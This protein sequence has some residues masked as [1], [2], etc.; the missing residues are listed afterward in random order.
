MKKNLFIVITLCVSAHS[1]GQGEIDAYRFSKNDLSGTAR[2]QAMG[3]AFGAL[4]GD[5]TGVTINPA[6]IGI[7][8]SSEIIFNAGLTFNQTEA[9]FNRTE[10][11][12]GNAKLSCDNFAYVGYFPL[13]KDDRYSLNFGFIYN[14]LKSFDRKYKVSGERMGTSLTDYMADITFGTPQDFW[15]EEDQFY[16]SGHPHW[17]GI[18]GWNGYLINADEFEDQAYTGIL[19][20][21]ETVDP[22]LE[23]RERGSIDAYDF[24][25]GTNL[26]NKIYLGA[27]VTYTNISYIVSTSYGE[28]F[29]NGGGFN[30]N[31]EYDT[32]GSGLQ[33]KLGAILRP[34]DALRLGISYHSPAWYH[35]T[36]YYL[37]K[38]SPYGIYNDIDQLVEPVST[39]GNACHEYQFRTPDVWTLSAAL[40]LGQSSIISLDYEYKNYGTMNFSKQ[41]R[42]GYDFE[43]ENRYI[44]DDFKGAATIRAGLETRFTPQFAGRLGFARVQNPYGSK[45]KNGEIEVVTP[46]TI[47]NYTLEGDA[48]Y[49]TTGMGF[50]FTPRFYMDLAFVY[51]T[52]E[53]ELYFFSPLVDI[54]TGN[55]YL[56]STPAKLTNNSFK[57]QVTFGYKF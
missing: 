32:D 54:N 57:T 51:R 22:R 38:L 40:V 27:T 36:D 28:A 29:A 37:G 24:T 33:V 15:D 6:G 11:T 17:L 21:G 4:G 39:P 18:L 52:Q 9:L 50:R 10:E 34:A 48:L 44:N 19:N 56:D 46:G 23:V 25:L 7:Y 16:A 41:Y 8:R 49:L 53:D 47:P 55:R 30:L 43:W 35:L 14:R 42:D 12:Q 13:G 2:S 26:N 31:N 45:V 1:F 3:G 5:V 20:R